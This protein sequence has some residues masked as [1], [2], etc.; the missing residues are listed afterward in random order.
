MDNLEKSYD[1]LFNKFTKSE[2]AEDTEY[3]HVLQDK[4]YRKFIKDIC[5]NKLKTLEDIKK[6]AKLINKKVVKYDKEKNRWY[7]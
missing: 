5:N 1:L 4:I 6:T 3:A 2:L 7:A